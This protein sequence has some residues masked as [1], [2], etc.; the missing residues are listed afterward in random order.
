MHLIMKIC[1]VFHTVTV[2]YRKYHHE[3][4]S[5]LELKFELK[6]VSFFEELVSFIMNSEWVSFASAHVLAIFI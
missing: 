4:G 2:Y 6:S 3:R 5:F 1:I